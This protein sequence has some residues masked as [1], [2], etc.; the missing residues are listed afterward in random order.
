MNQT[1]AEKLI[2][3][4]RGLV[5]TNET[6][7]RDVIKGRNDITTEPRNGTTLPLDEEAF[8][9]RLKNR[10]LEDLR[11]DP[12]LLHLVAAQPELVVDVEKRT[13]D[14][15]GGTVKGRIGR[16]MAQGWFAGPKTSGQVRT[17]L[18]RTGTDPGSSNHTTA[19]NDY[20]KDGFLTRE[21]DGYQLA[22]GVQVSEN[23][24]TV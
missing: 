9:V 21:G 19:L 4:I 22:L 13:V 12:I 8:Y 24:V 15:D 3:T 16:L 18:K 2:A 17:E 5:D 6:K 1:D 23:R 14:I 20:V 7:P 11:V 10:L